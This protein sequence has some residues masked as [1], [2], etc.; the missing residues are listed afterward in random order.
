MEG[1]LVPTIGGDGDDRVGAVL[2]GVLAQLD[3]L[4]D[5]LVA[6]LSDPQRRATMALKARAAVIERHAPSVAAAARVALLSR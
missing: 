2:G 6:V 4:A 3:N 5:E 1:E